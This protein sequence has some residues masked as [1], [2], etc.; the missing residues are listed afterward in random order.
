M[1]KLIDQIVEWMDEST[2][3]YNK[4]NNTG[5][6]CQSTWKCAITNI[7]HSS[8]GGYLITVGM[9]IK[10]SSTVCVCVESTNSRWVVDK[11]MMTTIMT[12]TTANGEILNQIML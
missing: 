11:L 4:M 1:T 9:S 12:K 2:T 5:Y 8:V 7:N 3:R 6:R 10:Q